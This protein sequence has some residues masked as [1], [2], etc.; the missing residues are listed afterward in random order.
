QTGVTGTIDGGAGTDTYRRAFT[1]SGTAT[2]GSLTAVNFERE[3][4]QAIGADTVVT[5][6]A[7]TAL[8]SLGVLGDGQVV[9]TANV[10]GDL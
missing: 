1:K 5:I 9:N 3:D 10:D 8:T 4:V 7:S 2:L 6:G